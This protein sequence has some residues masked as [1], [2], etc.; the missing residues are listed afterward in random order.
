MTRSI[1][2]P[3]IDLVAFIQFWQPLNSKPSILG[4]GFLGQSRL[5]EGKLICLTGH[6]KGHRDFHHNYKAT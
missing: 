1:G 3:K 5:I 2:N 4:K 6:F